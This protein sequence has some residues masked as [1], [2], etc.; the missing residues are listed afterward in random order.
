MSLRDQ[1]T[2]LLLT[3]NEELN[4][5]RTLEA[6]RWAPRILI[7]DSGSTDATLDISRR[8]SQAEVVTRAFD[9]F[10]EQCNFGLTHIAAGWVLSMDADYE[11]SEDLVA[12]IGRLEP[13][14][15]VN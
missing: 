4:I 1:I 13:Q 10:A 6:V 9:G 3:Y 2:V 14:A 8:Y 15:D 7:V 12:E 5:T 11:L